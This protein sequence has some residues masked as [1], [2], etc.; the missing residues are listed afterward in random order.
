MRLRPKISSAWLAALLLALAVGTQRPV[1]AAPEIPVPRIFTNA[2]ALR[3]LSLPQVSEGVPVRLE[4]VVTLV[5]PSRNLLVLQD[6]SGAVALSLR[7]P[8]VEDRGWQPG[9][10]VRIESSDAVPIISTFPDFPQKPS[11]SNLLPSFS[12]P[13]NWGIYYLARMTA[14]VVPPATG[15]Y[16]FYIASKGAAELWLSTNAEPANLKK[17][18]F[19]PTGRSTLPEQWN[20][21]LTQSSIPIHLQADQS[22][23]IAAIQEQHGGRDDNLAV[24]WEGPGIELSPIDGKFLMQYPGREAHGVVREYWN[25]YFVGATEPLTSGP[26]WKSTFEI[27]NPRITLLG[28]GNFPQPTP[29]EVGDT[30]EPADNF[31]WV[32]SEGVA[33]FA[34]A[35]RNGA[36]FELVEGKQRVHVQVLG[37]PASDVLRLEKMRVRLRGVCES[38]ANAKG[39]DAGAI[40]R[41]PSPREIVETSPDAGELAELDVVPI[42]DLTPANPSLAWD[43]QIRIRGTVVRQDTNGF[44]IEG[45]GTFCG[46][47]STDGSHWKQIAPPVEI[48]MS[49]SALAGLA[50]C[51]YSS[52]SLV[53]ATF[54]SVS[55]PEREL[56][57]V[58]IINTLP[59]GKTTRDGSIYTI[60]GGGGSV[61]ST[62]D[63]FHYLYQQLTGDGEIV[64][65]VTSLEK[66]NAHSIAGIM[67][68]DSV[69]TK[70]TFASLAMSAGGGAV[71]QFRLKKDERGAT[72]PLRDC[73]LP[74]W[75]K[76]TRRHIGTLVRADTNFV[77]RPGEEVDLAGS[78]EWKDGQPILLHVRRLEDAATRILRQRPPGIPTNS[79]NEPP[80]VSIAQLVPE[81]GESLR[82]GSGGVYVRGVVTFSDRAYDT[83]YLVIQ[84]DTAGA[85]VH[86]NSRFS[87]KPLHL[88]DFVEFDL[89]SV[90]GQWPVPF[91]PSRIDVLGKAELPEPVVHPAEY[92]L[93]RRGD[94]QWTEFEG[95]VREA[96]Q[97]NTLLLMRRDG[98]MTIWVGQSSREQLARYVDAS[99]HIRGVTIRTGENTRTLL[100]PSMEFIDV[101]E[102]PPRDPF[103]IPTIPI[104]D[105]E[106]FNRRSAF[107]RVAVSGVVTYRG[108]RLLVVQDQSSGVR[109][110]TAEGPSDIRVGD[111][112]EAVGF[113]DFENS[114]VAL[115]ETL[116]RKIGAGKLPKPVEPASADL[117]DYVHD[118][119]V[120]K[121]TGRVL[122]QQTVG[123]DQV[124]E[125]QSGRR[126]FRATLAKGLADLPAIPAGSQVEVT[127]VSWTQPTGDAVASVVSK[128]PLVP[129]DVLLRASSDV[130]VRQR[131]PWWTWKHTAAT[132]GAFIFVLGLALFWIRLLRQQ[133]AQRTNELQTAMTKLERETEISATLTE[134]NRLAGELHDGLEQGL[135]AIMMQL[136]GLESK[137]G[138]NP[139]EAA[140][141]LK[142][143][144][145]MIRFSRTEVRHSLWDWKSP[146]LANKNLAAALSDIANRM[147]AGNQAKVSVRISGSAFPLPHAAEHHLL[148][149]GQEAL[150]NALK[151]AEAGAIYLDLNYAED[152][153]Q[154]SVR[155]TGRGFVPETVLSGT[156]GHFGL[157][158]LRSRARKMGG[159]L[160]VTSA[161]G[162]GTT[163]EVT[164]P[165][166]GTPSRSQPNGQ[167]ITNEN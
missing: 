44:F 34:T 9:D 46:Y 125:L 155:D 20:K 77:A 101:S 128:G 38:V 52:T 68:R 51:S 129:F 161:P 11:G 122:E 19:V 87:R 72:V 81:E 106:G 120:V 57:D 5:D 137:L 22:Y 150:T 26:I 16:T 18:A 29:L 111:L 8:R 147:S 104:A 153:V 135:S 98:L 133:V 62:L 132:V 49:E 96:P 142:L 105:L 144:R 33:E 164:V 156:G 91:E 55:G 76:L 138:T 84:D 131:P 47:V 167:S 94:W 114:S 148:R 134:R 107:H 102:P 25:D 136:D 112:I 100:V 89:R 113:P 37:W 15:N 21:Y 151:Y 149:I 17:I 165:V 40:I 14:L 90:N 124:L 69:D 63:Q 163:V 73:P 41:V 83:N 13:T 119:L 92:S 86:L 85:L 103:I 139:G 146:A 36:T 54:D 65:R 10:R 117:G 56:Y 3:E 58:D 115:T 93:A 116:V 31:R 1:V 159:R 30:I 4:G 28:Q 80:I 27:A 95:I 123:D 140:R 97:D 157:Q 99:V 2:A 158:N 152:S 61:G 110:D 74:C 71:F 109:L 108:D 12:A 82:E 60:M 70:A 143:A 67:I 166:N 43:R 88:G 42:S 154:L 75:L 7:G 59:A 121:L 39:N 6:S 79:S 127:G 24:G 64:A 162:Q 35:D 78:L 48:P 45:P 118:A 141:Y 145:N 66:I 126:A 160:T 130:I 32:E 23:F 50:V 53:K